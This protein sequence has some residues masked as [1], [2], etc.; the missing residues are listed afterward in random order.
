MKTRCMIAESRAL[1]AFY[2]WYIMDNFGDAPLVT[3]PTS[4]LP[5]KTS[6]RIFMIYSQRTKRVFQRSPN[7]EK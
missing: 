5:V 7:R 4:E 6:R 1:R 2:Y 3:E